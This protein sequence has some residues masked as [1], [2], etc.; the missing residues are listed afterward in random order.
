MNLKEV[1]KKKRGY[2]FKVRS[3]DANCMYLGLRNRAESYEFKRGY[4]KRKEVM[5]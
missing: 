3:Y 1:M 2:E 4:E 5:P